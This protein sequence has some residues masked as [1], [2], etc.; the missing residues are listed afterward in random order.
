LDIAKQLMIKPD[1][2]FTFCKS[3]TTVSFHNIKGDVTPHRV[4]HRIDKE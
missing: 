1:A 3:L 4:S 2:V